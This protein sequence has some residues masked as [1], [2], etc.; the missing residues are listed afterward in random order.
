MNVSADKEKEQ[1][2]LEILKIIS[3]HDISE[4][5]AA[6]LKQYLDEDK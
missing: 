6:A 1:K 4:E 2:A 3:E 5:I